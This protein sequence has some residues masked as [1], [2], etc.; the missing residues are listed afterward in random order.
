M[1]VVDIDKDLDEAI[2]LLTP[3]KIS[4]VD[5]VSEARMLI[6]GD[7]LQDLQ[8]RALAIGATVATIE[9]CLNEFSRLFPRSTKFAVKQNKQS[10]K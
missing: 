7:K 5:W 4:L 10:K 2:A 8:D 1:K 6:D 3:I 9:T